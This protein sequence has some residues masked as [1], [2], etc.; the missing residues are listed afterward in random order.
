MKNLQIFMSEQEKAQRAGVS[1]RGQ[2]KQLAHG[3]M[4]EIRRPGNT[5]VSYSHTAQLRVESVKVGR[6]GRPFL[7]ILPLGTAKQ[8]I[9]AGS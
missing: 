1:R 8:A 9:Y 7:A 6:V 5:R 2:S 3:G 4:G